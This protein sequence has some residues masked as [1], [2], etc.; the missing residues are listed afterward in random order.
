MS[1]RR[2]PRSFPQSEAH[3]LLQAATR[4]QDRLILATGLYMGLRVSE[5]TKLEIGDINWEESTALIREAKGDKDR[6]VPIPFT[7]V[8]QLRDLIGTRTGGFLFSSP[9]GGGRLSSRAIQR[10]IKRV[11]A[12]A[13]IVDADKPRKVTPHRLRHTA[14][15]RLLRSG[16]DLIQV[17]DFLGHSSVATTQI[18]LSATAEGLKAA[19]EKA[20]EDTFTQPVPNPGL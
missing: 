20:S 4:T 15:T 9:H 14:A 2:L 12:R 11:A 18:Y 17:R 19:V 6:V 10:M 8:K 1:R 13:G 3:A 7:L 16:A 5:L